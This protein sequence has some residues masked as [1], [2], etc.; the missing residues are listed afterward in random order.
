VAVSV[1]FGLLFVLIVH[2]VW[3]AVVAKHPYILGDWQINYAG[4]FVRRGLLGEGARWWN[5]LLN[6]DFKSTVFAIQVLAYAA[7]FIFS[8]PVVSAAV[9]RYPIFAF[10]LLS[11][12]TF[13]FAAAGPEGSGRKEIVFLAL[14]AFVAWQLKRQAT[15]T[16]VWIVAFSVALCA[17]VLTHEMLFIFT[18]FSLLLLAMACPE[19][20]RPPLL[21]LAILPA[22]MVFLL[23]GVLHGDSTRIGEI[24]SSLGSSAPAKCASVGA[25]AWLGISLPNNIKS[26]YYA[27]VKMPQMLAVAAMSFGLGLLPFFLLVLD[28]VAAV[29]LRCT[30]AKRA[31]AGFA[32]AA[33]VVPWPLFLISDWGRWMHII[34]TSWTIT[35][36]F[37]LGRPVAPEAGMQNQSHGW[38]PSQGM[39]PYLFAILLIAYAVAWN[40]SGVCCPEHLGNGLLGRALSLR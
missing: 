29:H 7:F 40:M 9:A 20:V 38:S 4:G 1:Y 5:L 13:S 30:L 17:V 12:L 31:V 25:I 32:F 14:L 33:L 39:E 19:L 28:R 2:G 23:S 37:A 16:R 24:C 18:P 27:L 21:L 35:V 6:I 36:A 10:A 11:P 26:T 22:T 15:Y 34:V 3:A 8:L